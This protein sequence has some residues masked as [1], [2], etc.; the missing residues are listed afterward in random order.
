MTGSSSTFNQLYPVPTDE[1]FDVDEPAKGSSLNE[2]KRNRTKLPLSN[3]LENFVLE[4][5]IRML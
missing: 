5:A 4:H 1:Q 2:L 3:E